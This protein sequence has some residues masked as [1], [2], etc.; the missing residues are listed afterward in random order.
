MTKLTKAVPAKK[1]VASNKVV[2]A[3]NAGKSRFFT[4]PTN[5]DIEDVDIAWHEIFA[6]FYIQ[7]RDVS[8]TL[9]VID[10][11]NIEKLNNM[12]GLSAVATSGINS[13]DYAVRQSFTGGDVSGQPILNALSAKY[14]KRTKDSVINDLLNITLTYTGNA[15]GDEESLFPENLFESVEEISVASGTNLGNI[16]TWKAK[17]ISIDV[18]DFTKLK[19]KELLEYIIA[20][21]DGNMSTGL[22]TYRALTGDT[23]VDPLVVD[24][25]AQILAG[26]PLKEISGLDTG[27]GNA[28]LYTLEDLM[29][30]TADFAGLFDEESVPEVPE[31]ITDY[32]YKVRI[33]LGLWLNI[34]GDI[35]SYLVDNVASTSTAEKATFKAVLDEF[36]DLANGY[37][38]SLPLSGRVELLAGESY[39]ILAYILNEDEE[40]PSL[41]DA[42][43]QYKDTA[44]LSPSDNKTGLTAAQ[45][46]KFAIMVELN[47]KTTHDDVELTYQ[48]L[49]TAY[50][51]L[52][53][54]ARPND[55]VTVTTKVTGVVYTPENFTSPDS[56]DYLN[57]ETIYAILKLLGVTDEERIV[58]S[59][60]GLDANDDTEAKENFMTVLGTWGLLPVLKLTKG[61]WSNNKTPHALFLMQVGSNTTNAADKLMK[62]SKQFVQALLLNKKALEALQDEG[63]D[64][65][66]TNED[67]QLGLLRLIDHGVN[68]NDIYT[69]L[70]TTDA[71]RKANVK[72]LAGLVHTDPVSDNY[73]TVDWKNVNGLIVKAGISTFI[74]E[75]NGRMTVGDDATMADNW[76]VAFADSD[77]SEYTKL[78]ASF[79]A[80]ELLTYTKTTKVYKVRDGRGVLGMEETTLAFNIEKILTAYNITFAQLQT[81]AALADVSLEQ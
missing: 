43:Y 32:Y 73:K 31:E 56:N 44:P 53:K 34:K 13:S 75:G 66:D 19:K 49:G 62:Y 8:G 23:Y 78:T 60:N 72:T 68:V 9:P 1:A 71:I 36:D 46:E 15:S 76:V 26:I 25:E 55:V 59:V 4:T 70:G 18:S 5:G 67:L 54:V 37:L 42:I 30:S 65:F 24:A 63:D 29:E 33:A 12:V 7:S 2:P 17:E 35:L 80:G 40:L 27:S 22:I 10:P 74:D 79:T 6:E 28:N 64:D 16:T 38:Y 51:V 52:F 41:I 3:K 77:V 81:E 11:I 21:S 50:A 14:I 69:F 48:M 20:E 58:L 61:D 47:S 45:L 39:E 57:N